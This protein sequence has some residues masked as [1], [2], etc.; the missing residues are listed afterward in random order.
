MNVI[1]SK[2]TLGIILDR[3]GS[4]NMLRNTG[5]YPT[6]IHDSERSGHLSDCQCSTEYTNQSARK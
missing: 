3:D 2:F 5:W 1:A 6:S 4:A